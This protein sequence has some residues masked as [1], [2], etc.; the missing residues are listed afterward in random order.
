MIDENARLLSKKAKEALKELGTWLMLNRIALLCA[1]LLGTVVHFPLFVKALVNPDSLSYTDFYLAGTWE[2]QLGRW[3]LPLIDAVFGGPVPLCLAS[4]MSLALLALAGVVICDTLGITSG[5]G[6][7]L[8][9]CLL[10]ISP[11]VAVTL[12]YYY[13]SRA[14]ALAYLLTACAL[15]V[16]TSSRVSKP[17]WLGATAMMIF[18]LS[19]YQTSIDIALV[20]LLFA[21]LFLPLLRGNGSVA[22]FVGLMLRGVWLAFCLAAYYVLAR[23]FLLLGG[24]EFATYGGASSIGLAS[25]LMALP[26]TLR[27]LYRQFG[28]MLLGTSVARNAFRIRWADAGIVALFGVLLVRGILGGRAQRR[29]DEGMVPRALMAAFALLALPLACNF[30]CLFA[31]DNDLAMRMT[32]AYYLTVVCMVLGTIDLIAVTRAQEGTTLRNAGTLAAYACSLL[33][34]W[35]YA[36]QVSTDYL[37]MS[38]KERDAE[39]LVERIQSTAD[40]YRLDNGTTGAVIVLGHPSKGNFPF[41]VAGEELSDSFA[42][43]TYFWD[44]E[45]TTCGSW[46]HLARYALGTEMNT[47]GEEYYQSLLATPQI[48]SMSLY[49]AQGS[50][51][52]YEGNIVVK[53]ADV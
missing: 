31:H 2:Y 1:M 25:T 50:V 3:G 49:P 6:R 41:S 14:Y 37:V 12:T 48:Q 11:Y 38:A 10:C 27:E 21:T 39:Q 51:M 40:Q 52:E 35:G 17:S 53:V 36:S 30:V 32:P 26:S 22:D 28:V 33:L 23:V 29:L 47:C 45:S 46:H 13:C 5:V 16:V 9:C 19:L 42:H 18:A 34:V 44:L 8:A 7:T 24:L 20:L 43:Q 15:R 4:V